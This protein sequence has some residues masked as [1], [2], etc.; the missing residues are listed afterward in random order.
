MD[1]IE[2]NNGK[3]RLAAWVEA[4]RP[5][6]LFAS[7]SPVI[8]GCA[9]AYRDGAFNPIPA[10]LCVFV[11][12]LAQIASNF[13]NDYFDYKKGAD[14]DDRLGPERAVASGW[15]TPR[16]M[17]KA[18]FITLGLSCLCGCMLIFYGG[19]WL[20]PIGI[21]MAICVFAYSAGPYP[22][23]YYG[24]GDVFVLIFY[25][26][27]P[28][29]FTYFVQAN[30]FSFLGFIL[31]LAVG[32]LGINILVVNNYRD[33]EQDKE[34]RK[35]TTIVM[36]GR[37][38][39]RFFYLIN[40][41]LAILIILPFLFAG[42]WW[43]DLLFAGFFVLFIF[44]WLDLGKLEGKALNKTLGKTSRNLFIYSLILSLVLLFY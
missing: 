31:S 32:L 3:S 13:A 10:I 14:R 26:I 16:S 24:M 29:C 1:E 4:S 30:A 17:L 6:T 44:T 21:A 11:A 12:L 33:Y 25:G 42:I 36:F 22:L 37:T 7:L 43:I 28:V 8:V 39:G 15:I 27:V 38:F 20:L 5:K 34:S 18:T 40:G 2:M 9:L 23:S 41:I 35:Y 19:W